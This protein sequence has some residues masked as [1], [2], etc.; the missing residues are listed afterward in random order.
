LPGKALI[1]NGERKGRG[2]A[3]MAAAGVEKDEFDALHSV[4]IMAKR[5]PRQTTF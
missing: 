4:P 5:I 1:L 2:G 3:T